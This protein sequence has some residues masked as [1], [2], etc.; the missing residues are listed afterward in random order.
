[1]TNGKIQD[2]DQPYAFDQK[3]PKRAILH[4]GMT[5]SAAN[6]SNKSVNHRQNSSYLSVR[7]NKS[8]VIKNANECYLDVNDTPKSSQWVKMP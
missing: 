1:M 5:K 3:T 6:L 2:P 8:R 4:R 7:S